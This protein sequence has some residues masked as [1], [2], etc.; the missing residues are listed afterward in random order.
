MKLSHRMLR[1]SQLVTVL[2]GWHDQMIGSYLVCNE[3]S[4][5]QNILA[6]CDFIMATVA[7][8]NGEGYHVVPVPGVVQLPIAKGEQCVWEMHTPKFAVI[9]L[10]DEG[11]ADL[12]EGFASFGDALRFVAGIAP[13]ERSHW[14]L[15]IDAEVSHFLGRGVMTDVEWPDERA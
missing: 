11:D 9:V 2:A 14:P 13:D 15:V 12:F 10:P 7:G 8:A 5:A 1:Q 4:S 3:T 6:D